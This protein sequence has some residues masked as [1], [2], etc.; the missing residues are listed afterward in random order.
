MRRTMC[1][2][3][4]AGQEC[5]KSVLPWLPL[6]L[7]LRDDGRSLLRGGE[8][9]KDKLEKDA[10]ASAAAAENLSGRK[11]PVNI[12]AWVKQIRRAATVLRVFNA[13]IRG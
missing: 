10:A 8:P 9:T 3:S 6:F 12:T 13:N 1:S 7:L 5:K 2:S 11:E 4:G